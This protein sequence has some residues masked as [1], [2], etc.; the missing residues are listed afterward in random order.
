[1]SGNIYQELYELGEHGETSPPSKSHTVEI[2]S[3]GS[4]TPD[5]LANIDPKTKTKKGKKNKK[6]GKEEKKVE[7]K[8][9]YLQLY[10]FATSWD[11]TCV[12]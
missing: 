7:P 6:E 10:R 2:Q 11:W 4:V 5:N 12:M 8:V 3:Q 9:S 1:M